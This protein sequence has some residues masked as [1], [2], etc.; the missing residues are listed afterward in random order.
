MINRTKVVN[1]TS[2]ATSQTITNF[3]GNSRYAGEK[4][5]RP[6]NPSAKS[7]NIVTIVP[8]QRYL[9]DEGWLSVETTCPLPFAGPSG[10]RV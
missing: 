6:S 1:K 9:Y 8:C 7:K 2:Q 4:M 5:Y 10:E 3:V